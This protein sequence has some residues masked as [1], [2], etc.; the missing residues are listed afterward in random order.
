LEVE[1]DL[2]DLEGFLRLPP[3][4]IKQLRKALDYLDNLSPE[5]RAILLRDVTARQNSISQLRTAIHDDMQ[6][7]TPAERSILASYWRSLFAEE[8]QALI[9]RFNDAGAN[10][11][12]RKEII[13]EMLKAAKDKGIQ[14]TPANTDRPPGGPRGNSPQGARGK[15]TSGN[16]RAGARPAGTIATASKPLPAPASTSATN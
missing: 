1:N 2:A 13:Q 16:N 14:A 4:R 6:L 7:L 15:G 8:L 3:E 12:A 11:D 9:K 10:A 5:Q